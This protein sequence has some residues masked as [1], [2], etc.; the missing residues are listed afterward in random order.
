MVMERPFDTP[1]VSNSQTKLVV[2]DFDLTILSIHSWGERVRP[3]M[4]ASRCLED[5]VADLEFFRIFIDRA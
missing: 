4:V 5:D 2:F 3:E 1:S